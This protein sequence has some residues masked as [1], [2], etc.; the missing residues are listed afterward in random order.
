MR[1][2][3]GTKV[4][5]DLFLCSLTGGF[6][7]G[8][9]RLDIGLVIQLLVDLLIRRMLGLDESYRSLSQYYM[10]SEGIPHT[11][12]VLV[13]GLLVLGACGT[14]ALLGGSRLTIN[15]LLLGRALAR[16]RLG[17]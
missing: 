15:L 9:C 8:D 2:V 13:G 1:R 12:F 14:T 11:G 4:Y 7:G 10:V 6:G 5:L 3:G 16:S 17:S